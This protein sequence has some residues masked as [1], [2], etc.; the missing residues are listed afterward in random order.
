VSGIWADVLDGAERDL[1]AAESALAAGAVPDPRPWAPDGQMPPAT[2]AEAQRARAVLERLEALIAD[3]A[4]RRDADRAELDQ[5]A[6]R[7]NA[8][9]SYGAS[10]S[11]TQRAQVDAPPADG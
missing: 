9:R 6:A 2:P 11:C 3:M 10:T 8:A 1:D 5:L 4:Q 7:R